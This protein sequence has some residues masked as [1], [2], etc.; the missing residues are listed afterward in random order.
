MLLK[1][2]LPLSLFFCVCG[3]KLVSTDWVRVGGG[4]GLY[5][6]AAVLNVHV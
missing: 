4:G 6:S 3:E 1:K 5:V 2:Y